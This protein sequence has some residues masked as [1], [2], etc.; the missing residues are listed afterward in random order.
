MASSADMKGFFK[1]RK[2]NAGISKPSA[3]KS[4]PK[5]KTSASFGSNTAQPPALIAHGSP[6]LQENHDANEEVLRQF[7]MNMS[8]GPC[9]GMKRIDRWNRAVKLGMNPPKDVHRLL[10]SDSKVCA[11]SLWDGRV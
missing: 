11:D 6:D 4:K 8:Y 5:S 1:Q 10:T 3:T 9:V 2:K 7:D